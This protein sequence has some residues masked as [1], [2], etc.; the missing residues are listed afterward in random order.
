MKIEGDGYELYCGDCLDVL[1]GLA[2]GSVD[3]VICD[4]PYGITS[5]AWDNVIP[6]APMWEAIKRVVKPQAA[7]AL[8][9]SQPF[10]SVLVC[11]NLEWFRYQWVWKKT[12][13][14]GFNHAAN[15]PLKNY[16]D[17]A[18][19]SDGIIQHSHLT[20]R[21]MT[22]HPQGLQ[23]CGILNRR[24]SKGFNGT[25]ERKS[26]TNIYITEYTNY[27]RMVLEFDSE[28][29]T[30]HPTQKPVD[31]LAYLVRTYTNP[32]DLVL[33]FTMGSGTTGVAALQTSRRFVGCEIS[34]DYFTI[35]HRRIEDAARA[36]AGL[37]KQLNG[38][39]NDWSESPL[40]Q[41][42]QPCNQ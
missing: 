12:I 25:M 28:I 19:F 9:G 42:I 24:G 16:E 4:L 34:P 2:A 40:F 36:A 38:H 29:N 8:F 6:L 1:P 11:S 33:D 17:I 27:P 41:E 32:G 15:M 37:P 35:A 10:T 18:I 26:Q 14:T 20:N 39:T 13:S 7:V 23:R 3:A 5:C 22:Y 30:I 21:R 31:L